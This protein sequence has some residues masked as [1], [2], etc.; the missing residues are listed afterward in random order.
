MGQV[1]SLCNCATGCN[2]WVDARDDSVGLCV[3]PCNFVP[4][5]QAEAVCKVSNKWDLH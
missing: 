3:S 2:K 1:E 4:Y 5:S